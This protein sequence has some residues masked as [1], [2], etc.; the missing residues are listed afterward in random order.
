[1]LKRRHLIA[2]S[3]AGLAIARRPPAL[4]APRTIG[5]LSPDSRETSAPF[6]QA[7]VTG[8]RER[9]KENAPLIIER[10]APKGP[11]DV[12]AAA[13]DLERQQVSLIV[14]QG[15]ATLSAVRAVPGTP[16]VFAYS[17]DPVLAGVA[18][19][20]AQPGGNATGI[21]F[22]SVELMAKRVDY[23]R[24]TTP[25][26]RRLA[27]LSNARHPGEEREIEACLKAVEASGVEV[28]VHRVRS[29][30]EVPRAVEEA[31]QTA[32]ALLVLSSA[33]MVN[34]AP[35]IAAQCMV[36]KVPMVSGWA[37]MVRAGG[38]MSYGPNLEVGISHLAVYIDRILA[39][40][41]PATLPVE[42]PTIFELV[43]NKRTATAIDVRLPETLLAQ[44]EQVI[45]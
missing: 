34:A 45:E 44:A 19:S 31:V 7:L 13:K 22:M 18:Q 30:D 6:F 43:L 2:A 39:G 5:W 8:L 33:F 29:F 35:G 26:A 37:S 14:A 10:Y 9:M 12:A 3:A 11:D 27:L 36:R 41:A 16:V 38:L 42:Q 24:Q 20:L 25:A 15:T 17:G 21:S 28:A 4:A 1:M 32:Q 40:A 23:L